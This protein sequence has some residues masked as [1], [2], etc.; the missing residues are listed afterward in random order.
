M[1]YLASQKRNNLYVKNIPKDWTE[2]KVFDLFISF[3]NIKSLVLQ[4]NNSRKFAFVCYDSDKGVEKEYGA[5][6]AEKSIQELNNRDMGNGL[7]LVVKHALKKS[8]R[9]K[10]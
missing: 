1:N 10:K 2:E 7:K 6:C 4:E 8:D 5:K 3:G 9:E